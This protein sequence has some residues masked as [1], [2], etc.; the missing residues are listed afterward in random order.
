MRSIIFIAIPGTLA[1]FFVF[2]VGEQLQ[3]PVLRSIGIYGTLLC[4]GILLVC[5]AVRKSRPIDERFERQDRIAGSIEIKGGLGICGN[6][7]LRNSTEMPDITQGRYVLKV[8]ERAYASATV[9][10]SFSL[11]RDR[12]IEGNLRYE[13]AGDIVVEAVAIYLVDLAAVRSLNTASL[14]EKMSSIHNRLIHNG[15]KD[16]NNALVASIGDGVADCAAILPDSG[17]GSFRLR[18]DLDDTGLLGV[19]CL[20]IGEEE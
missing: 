8:I 14:H 11:H 16:V 9:P 17:N 3:I 12:K 13:S 4:G 15:G 1:F 6:F 7:M 2:T 10:E 20:L 5:W 19:S 18:K